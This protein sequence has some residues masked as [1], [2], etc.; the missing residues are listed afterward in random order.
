MKKSSITTFGSYFDRYIDLADDI[1]LVEALEQSLMDIDAL[2]MIHL[3]NLGNWAYAEGKW[4][5]KDIIQHII[6]TERVFC[7]RTLSYARMDPNTP[8][9]YDENDYANNARAN[10]KDIDDLIEELKTVRLSTIALFKGFDD[11]DLQ[12]IGTCWK[13]PMSVLAMGFILVG[14][15]RHHF[16]VMKERYAGDR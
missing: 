11:E 15:Q 16:A 12:K 13:Y 3:R 2:D 6:D 10:R 5:V 7:Y 4:S 14:H 8:L 1:E 9:G